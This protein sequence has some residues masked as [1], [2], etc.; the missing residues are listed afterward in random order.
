MQGCVADQ[1]PPD[2]CRRHRST[3]DAALL[4]RRNPLRPRRRFA[5]LRHVRW[6][7]SS[8]RLP[9]HRL[10]AS[11]DGVL[12]QRRPASRTTKAWGVRGAFN[13]NWDPYWSSHC[14]AAT[15]RSRTAVTARLCY[16]PASAQLLRG[17]NARPI[18]ATRTST[19]P[20]L[21]SS[22]SGLLSRT[23]RSRVKCSGFGLDQ[24]IGWNVPAG[25]QPAATKPTAVVRV[26]GPEHRVL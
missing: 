5:E 4:Q 22:P 11:S 18:P 20:R 12:H 14:S 19:S 21:V 23:S 24:K 16:W 15:P 1:E 8:R 9:E 26:Q 7:Q 10:G 13:H 2:G 25:R 17:L 6:H 3:C